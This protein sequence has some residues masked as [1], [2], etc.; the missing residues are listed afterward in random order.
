MISLGQAVDVKVIKRHPTG[1]GLV[2]LPVL[3]E[4][5]IDL[6]RTA[7]GGDG[8]LAITSADLQQMASNFAIWTGPVGVNVSPHRSNEEAG[9][10]QPGF[11]EALSVSDGMLWATL[12]LGSALF[13]AVVEDRAWRGFSVDM[14]FNV[15]K[16]TKTFEGWSVLRGVFTNN[17]ATD[18]N[19]RVAAEAGLCTVVVPLQS[20]ST[21]KELEMGTEQT[22]SLASHEAKV[23]ELRAAHGFSGEKVAALE[24]QLE[25]KRQAIKD[26]TSERDEANA[27]LSALETDHATLKGSSAVLASAETSLKTAKKVLESKVVELSAELTE[28]R[29]VNL[30]IKVNEIITEAINAGVPPAMFEGYETDPGTWMSS[31]YASLESFNE[32]VSALSGI[33][34]DVESV[35]VKSGADLKPTDPNKNANLSEKEVA[36]LEEMG[37]GVDYHGAETESQ[38]KTI[39]AESKTEDK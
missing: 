34:P 28:S 32:V 5:E 19:F 26:L 14:G 31:K 2:S 16:P 39:A 9:G 7:G 8:L 35:P 12:D 30:G 33:L 36:I 22:I 1:G 18:V 3:V 29:S 17:P 11:I 10:P 21:G 23:A 37:L 6:E 38:A 4:S 27:K 13:E 25:S 24:G 20:A 15:K